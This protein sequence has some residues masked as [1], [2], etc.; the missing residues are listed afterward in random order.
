MFIDAG[1][2]AIAPMLIGNASLN[3]SRLLYDCS[4]GEPLF[5]IIEDSGL[6]S[7]FIGDLLGQLDAD[8]LLPT[9]NDTFASIKSSVQAVVDSQVN[10]FDLDNVTAPLTALVDNANMT[11]VAATL[12]FDAA[13]RQTA[14]LAYNFTEQAAVITAAAAT[15]GGSR[16]TGLEAVATAFEGFS[17]DGIVNNTVLPALDR[18]GNAVTAIKAVD[19]Q[20]LGE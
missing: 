8:Q 4:Q 19:W 10:S 16:K 7:G 17:R 14:M 1:V 20:A 5:K 18:M 15:A 9:L 3:A 13:A 6:L 12:T 2:S 11:G